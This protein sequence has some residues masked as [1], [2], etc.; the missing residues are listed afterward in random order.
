MRR[1]VLWVV[2]VLVLCGPA[3]SGWAAPGHGA[4]SGRDVSNVAVASRQRLAELDVS[5][6]A[7]KLLAG[8][9]LAGSATVGNIGSVLARSST[10]D[11][12]WKSSDSGGLVQL[13]RFTVPALKPGQ[14]HK[15]KFQFD[16]PKGVSGRHAVSVCADVLDQVQER[17]RKNNCRDA[18]VITIPGSGVKASGPTS[19]EPSSPSGSPPGGSSP[20]PA[21]PTPTPP[22]SSPPDTVIDSGPSGV[23]GQSSVTFT[24]HGSDT[25][26][27]FQCSLDGAPWASCTSPQVYTAL[28]EGAH[29]FQVRA[30]NVD[31]EVDPTPAEA[32]W[33]VDTIVPVVT[34]ASPANASTTNQNKPTFSGSASNEPLDSP[35][36]TL[37]IYPG[38]TVSGSPVQTLT[39]TELGGAWSVAAAGVLPDGTYT[40]QASQSDA[41]GGTATSSRNIFTIDTVPPVVTFTTPAN[42]SATNHGEPTFSGTAGTAAGDLPT[43]TVKIYS[44]STPSGTAVQ[45]L[46]TTASGSSWSVR[47]SSALTDGTYTAQ[48]RQSDAPGNVGTSA[49]STFAV[50]TTAPKTIITSAPSGHIPTGPVDVAFTSNQ[51]GGTF[52]CSLDGAD[53]TTCTS[54]DD[55]TS[56]SPGPHTFRVRAVNPAG[57]EDPNP[58][59]ATWDSVAPQIDLCGQI[60]HNQTLSTDYTS[61]YVLT[62]GL[63]V[64]EGATL[65]AEAGTVIK[66]EDGGSLTVEGSLVAAGTPASPVTFTSVNDDSVGGMTGDAMPGPSEWGGIYVAGR[67]SSVSFD[68]AV[69]SYD[70]DVRIAETGSASIMNSRFARGTGVYQCCEAVGGVSV[71]AWGPIVVS[72]NTVVEGPGLEVSQST[73]SA[74]TVVSGNYIDNEQYTALSVSSQGSITVQNNTV[75][76][77]VGRAY[78]LHSEALSPADITGNTATDDKENVLGVSGTLAG[79]WALPYAGLPVVL[80][81]GLTVPEGKTLSVAAGTVLKSADGSLQ[82]YGSLIADGTTSEPVTFTSLKDD[83]AGGDTNGDGN[84]S[85][86]GPSEWGGIYVAGRGSSV[87]FDD[88]VVSYDRDVRIAETGSAS[89]M[90]SRFARG[91]GVYQC[92]EAVGGVSVNAWGPIVVSDNTVVEGPGL[93]V[94]QNTPSAET[95]V[96][97]N[98]IDNEQYTALS[99]SSQGSITV[100]NNTVHSGVGRAYELHSEALS[101]ADI[102]PSLPR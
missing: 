86:P 31:G 41:A 35:T 6:A 38:S 58:P 30:I 44:G 54:P 74:E 55:L 1:T 93:E 76:S 18:G 48:A 95:V 37:K 7:V 26:D 51:S 85:S 70:R 5:T 24:F 64:E 69:V 90:N 60:S 2:L 33:T 79:S 32:T 3:L 36:V 77:G 49:P 61:E 84:E 43:V 42:G 89:I 25:N 19:S 62:C 73:P 15:A 66:A 17:S 87:S 52:Q 39:T 57:V 50:D 12:A 83:S 96:S 71:N 78:E 56:L 4:V 14:R 21:S 27:T 46:T 72:D 59:N 68:D 92:C 10:A 63:T 100:H 53:Y 45:T 97:G 8:N 23:M 22:A 34:L 80:D 67:G 98:Y 65:T 88:A 91:T 29:T 20:T 28:A 101:P 47:A 40:A 94:S 75:H 102:T 16:L 13:G 11:V 99:V 81:G 82:V 9:V